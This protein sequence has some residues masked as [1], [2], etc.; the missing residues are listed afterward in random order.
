MIPQSKGKDY[1]KVPKSKLQNEYYISTKFDGHYVQI[2]PDGSI[3]T[4]GGKLIKFVD[5]S[6]PTKYVLEAEFIGNADGK[7]GGRTKCGQLTTWRTNTAKGID[8]YIDGIFKVFDIIIPDMPFS[9]RL[10][11]LQQLYKGHKNIHVVQHSLVNA[12]DITKIIQSAK[13]ARTAGYEGLVG[14]APNHIHIPGKRTNEFVKFKFRP[15]VDLK[16]LD[17]L[18]GEGKYTGM[19]GAL[20]CVDAM[21]REVNVGSGLADYDRAQEPSAFI[22]KIVEVEY[23]QILDT[24][25]QPTFLRVRSDRDEPEDY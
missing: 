11:Y 20:V 14:K 23:E 13:I 8:N 2:H 12:T 21:G 10:T 19:I 22:N 5:F 17:I 6:Y 3:Y 25:I 24:Y 16:V 15:T 4:S 1:A 7:L 18:P 9:E